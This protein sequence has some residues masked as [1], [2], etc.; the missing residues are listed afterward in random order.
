MSAFTASKSSSASIAAPSTFSS[1]AIPLPIVWSTI[2]GIWEVVRAEVREI[3]QP[4]KWFLLFSQ[5]PI[6]RPPDLPSL[7]ELAFDYFQ[8]LGNRV[9]GARLDAI[10]VLAAQ[11]VRNQ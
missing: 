1:S 7:I 6:S 11:R 5:L 4:P 2:S 10:Q 8:H 9:P 3:E